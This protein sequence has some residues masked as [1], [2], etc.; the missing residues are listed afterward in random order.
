[1]SGAV[2]VLVALV[3]NGLVAALIVLGIVRFVQNVE[4]NLLQPL[5]QGHQ[6]H[7]HPVVIIVVVSVGYLLFG[8][9]G[10]VIAVPIAA[11]GYRVA[12]TL[13]HA[14]PDRDQASEGGGCGDDPPSEPA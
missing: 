13:R 9:P 7:L 14:D 6:V 3:S 11:V 8:I 2:A 1:M 5:V 12:A 4:G 10:A